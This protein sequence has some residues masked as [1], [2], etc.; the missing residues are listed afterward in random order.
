MN[1]ALIPVRGG[2]KSIPL[3]NIKEI[4]GKPLVYWT[5]LAACR[6][7]YLDRVYIA[8]DSEIIAETVRKFCREEKITE[9]SAYGNDCSSGGNAVDSVGFVFDKAEVIGRSAES[10]TDT[11]STE[12]VMLEFASKYSF[13]AEL[14]VALTPGNFPMERIVSCAVVSLTVVSVTVVSTGVVVSGGGSCVLR[15]SSIVSA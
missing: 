3:K 7:R 15:I 11:A 4:A 8:T 9:G 5:V 14:P 13:G 12:S 2:S 10:A 6:C 1:V